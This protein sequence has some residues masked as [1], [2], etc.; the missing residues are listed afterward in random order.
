MY[1]K[2]PQGKGNFEQV[3]GRETG[4]EGEKQEDWISAQVCSRAQVSEGS[5]VT[6]FSKV[7]WDEDTLTCPMQTDQSV[8]VLFSVKQKLLY[9]WLPQQKKNLEFT[10][11]AISSEIRF[12]GRR[13]GH[14]EHSNF[15]CLVKWFL[16]YGA[17]LGCWDENEELFGLEAKLDNPWTDTTQLSWTT[18]KG[19]YVTDLFRQNCL[20]RAD[21]M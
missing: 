20:Q 21:Y 13:Q 18:K 12:L 1:W 8:P 2:D 16:T 17:Q 4:N 6:T 19:D 14:W 9:S 10:W 5:E 3:W 11:G 15:C 7:S